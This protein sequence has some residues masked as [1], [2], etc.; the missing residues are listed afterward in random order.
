MARAVEQ[1]F[2]LS[3]NTFVTPVCYGRT[4]MNEEQRETLSLLIEESSLDN[5]GKFGPRDPDWE[6]RLRD[7]RNTLL[8]DS[9]E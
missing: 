8:E 6:R 7:L 9:D 5:S 1:T 4:M 3:T 2:Y